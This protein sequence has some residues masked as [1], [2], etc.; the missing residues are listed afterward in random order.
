[1]ATPCMSHSF[2]PFL[3]YCAS[4][5]TVFCA[6]MA[7]LFPATAVRKAL[8]LSIITHLPSHHKPMPSLLNNSDCQYPYTSPRACGKIS[9][10]HHNEVKKKGL[11]TYNDVL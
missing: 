5:L 2:R 8:V 6:S 3:P 9:Q 4:S 7:F 10:T 1:M 11:I